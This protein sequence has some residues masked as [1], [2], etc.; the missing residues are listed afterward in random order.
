MP[1]RRL[2]LTLILGVA[3]ILAVGGFF[4]GWDALR[5]LR[6]DPKGG[7]EVV[8]IPKGTGIRQVATILTQ[9]KIVHH[10][11][12]FI[13]LAKLEGKARLVRAGEYRFSPAMSY[14]AILDAL[15]KGRVLI[16]SVLIPEGFN[17]N[18]IIDRLSRL[19]L[20][21]RQDALDLASDP[22]FIAS[23]GLDVD[24][25][26]G[27]LFPAVYRLPRGL[28]AK[29]VLGMM[30][31]RFKREW[32]KIAPT[33]RAKGLSRRK[34]VILASIIEREAKINRERYLV[35]AVYHNRLK[36][37]M[38]LQADPTVI[39]GMSDDFEGKLTK[40]DLSHDSPYNTYRNTGLPPGP[41]CS[42]GAASLWAT[43]RPAK[44]KYLYFVAKGDG[45]HHFSTNYRDHARAVRR[46]QSA[47]R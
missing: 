23:Q 10:P 11:R 30:I 12:L 20:I 37:G 39:Y 45:S 1:W 35:S 6:A 19:N 14:A 8:M 24:T 25:L 32:K 47:R 18:Q 4:R 31:R 17:L 41:I 13:L 16:H 42:P 28:D 2:S 44:V 3:L 9:A 38:L 27:Y 29:T 5:D 22:E 26:E 46:F 36:K 7:P 43:V 40:Q 15:A 34:A 33:A 21:D